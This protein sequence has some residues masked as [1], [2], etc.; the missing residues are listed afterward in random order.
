MNFQNHMQ[1][2]QNPFQD[3]AHLY[4]EVFKRHSVPP[5]QL[6]GI[7]GHEAEPEKTLHLLTAGPLGHLGSRTRWETCREKEIQKGHR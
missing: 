6:H 4:I 5:E 1:G 2:S 3:L 7:P